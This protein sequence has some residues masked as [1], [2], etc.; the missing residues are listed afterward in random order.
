MGKIELLEESRLTEGMKVLVTLIPEDNE[1]QFWLGVSD[2]TLAEVWDNS[3]DDIYC[4][5]LQK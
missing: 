1:E 4:E 5:L 3:E 2:L